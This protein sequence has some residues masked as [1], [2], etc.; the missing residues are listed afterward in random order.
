MIKY[1]LDVYQSKFDTRDFHV[2]GILNPRFDLPK[3]IDYRGELPLAWDQGKE[4]ACSAFA[5]AGMKQWQ[6]LKDYG[7]TEE[8]SKYFIYNL[9]SNYPNEGMYPRDTMNILKKHG[10]ALKKSF[11]RD[12]IGVKEVPKRVLK[13]AKKNIIKGYARVATVDALKKALYKNGPCYI[14]FP[15]YKY[16]DI[17][18]KPKPNQKQ[19]LGG[20][21]LCVVGY[22]KKGF[23]I[24]N[25]WGPEWYDNGHTYYSYEDWGSHWEIWT[26]ID[27]KT[28]EPVIRKKWCMF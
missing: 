6:E 20:H 14:A 16:D 18:W 2:E 24:R 7:L 12:W 5:A 3:S 19:F 8:V 9:R 17:F 21:A 26:T 23:I 28:S 11:N 25:S 13:E 27:E 15:V 10:V 22:N 4:G 1:K